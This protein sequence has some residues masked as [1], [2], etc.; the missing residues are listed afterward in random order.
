M[1]KKVDVFLSVRIHT[2][3]LSKE[4][5]LEKIIL[6][7]SQ[8]KE[9]LNN[10]IIVIYEQ[11]IEN[12]QIDDINKDLFEFLQKFIPYKKEIKKISKKNDVSCFI[13]IYSYNF[14]MSF[15]FSK[16]NINLLSEIGASLD[17]DYYNM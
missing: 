1:K 7:Y 17:I 15:I 5:F 14:E 10:Q 2:N 12:N 13:A 8:I 16:E 3:Y 11:K 6:P 4:F 9:K